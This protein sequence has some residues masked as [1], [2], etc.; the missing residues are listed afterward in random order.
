[1]SMHLSRRS[2]V[3][4]GVG[5]AAG[6]AASGLVRGLPVWAEPVKVST[7]AAEKLGW[8]MAVQLYTY[9]RFPLYEALD[10]IAAL[11]VR[12][13]EICFFL[14]LD[15][16]RPNLTTS[17]NLPPDVCKELKAKLDDMGISLSAFYAEL[18]AKEEK[19]KKIF[20]FCREM[21]TGVIVAEPP[22][23]AFDMIEKLCEEYKVSL[24]IHNHPESPK[25]R[26]WSPETVLEVCKGRG[27]R[28]GACCDTGH[29]V[30]SGLDPVECLKKMEGRIN[31]FHLKDAA[32]KGNRKSEDAPL[33]EGAG[34]YKAVLA[35]LKRQGYKGLTTI[36][37]EKDTDHL[38][39]DM[40]KC[41]SFVEEQAKALGA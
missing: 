23:E 25:Q 14:K 2:V 5:L 9:R 11:G 16:A 15:K 20:E 10:K 41:V 21:G 4:S 32:E 19:A 26:Y 37:Y 38:Q 7:P 8:Q 6:A 24:A 12:H 34:S 29:W 3:R 22:P 13:I 18:G 35:E 40:V 33:G 27:K 36:E 39:D 31:A 28:I 1:M 17:D 30:R